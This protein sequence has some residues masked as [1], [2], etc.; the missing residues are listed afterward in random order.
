VGFGA[1]ILFIL[2]VGLLVLGPKRLHT[3]LGDV[4]RAKAKFEEASRGFKSQLT[5]ELEAASQGPGN[6][7]H[8]SFL[9]TENTTEPAHSGSLGCDY[10]IAE[11]VASQPSSRQLSG[12]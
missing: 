2:L 1:E 7:E 5:A 8:A 6:H 12:Q 3:V 9:A 4:A 10:E 11:A